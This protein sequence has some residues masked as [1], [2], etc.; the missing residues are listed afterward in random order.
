MRPAD[1]FAATVQTVRTGRDYDHAIFW[2]STHRTWSDAL[3]TTTSSWRNW[4][5]LSLGICAGCLTDG[6]GVSGTSSLAVFTETAG[7]NVPAVYFLDVEDFP[8]IQI[9]PNDSFVFDAVSEGSVL[10]ELTVATNCLVGG[11]NPR[12][13][14]IEQGE[15]ARTTFAVVCT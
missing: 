2:T 10:L 5:V 12:S 9:G 1:G 11:D 6:T 15:D 4:A 7:S 14:Q 8:Q 3:T 13:V